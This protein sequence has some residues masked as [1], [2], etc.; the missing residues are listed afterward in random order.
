MHKKIMAKTAKKLDKD[1]AHYKHEEHE[2]KKHHNKIK[3][4]HEHVEMKEAKSASKDLKKRV[5]S[6]HEY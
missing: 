2:A 5:K 6:S 3:A 4:K 1:A